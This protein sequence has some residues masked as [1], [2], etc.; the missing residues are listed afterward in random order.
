MRRF[1]NTDATDLPLKNPTE[2]NQSNCDPMQSI[3][4]ISHMPFGGL[5]PISSNG[6][7]ISKSR[8]HKQQ[9]QQNRRKAWWPSVALLFWPYR[10]QQ[11]NNQM[12]TCNIQSKSDTIPT[13]KIE[14]P[15]QPNTKMI[16]LSWGPNLLIRDSTP[17]PNIIYNIHYTLY[18][19]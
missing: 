8:Q 11:L 7:R 5:P 19:Y 18:T 17:K 6:H 9:Q 4:G 15:A 10:H 3:Y 1:R 13:N 2:P 12:W 16:I 14:A